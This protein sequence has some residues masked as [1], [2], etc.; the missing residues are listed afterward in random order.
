MWQ[1]AT[2]NEVHSSMNNLSRLVFIT[3]AMVA[4]IHFAP[5]AQAAEKGQLNNGAQVLEAFDRQQ[6]Q[7][8]NKTSDLSD[9]QKQLIMFMIGVPLLLL[10][11]ITGGLGV[12]TGVY[13]KQLFIAHMVCAGLTIT[14][15]IVHVIVGLVWFFPF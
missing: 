13:G 4:A 12:A 5:I 8:V 14:L 10:L 2:K 11:L 1:G 7:R 15:A 6:V 3:L 9:H